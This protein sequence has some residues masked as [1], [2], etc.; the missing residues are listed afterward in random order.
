MPIQHMP[1]QR[2]TEY[3]IKKLHQLDIR[4]A[5]LRGNSGPALPQPL[6]L[7]LGALLM[8]LLGRYLL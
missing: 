2:V 1:V 3:S 8:M 5:H 4:S 7:I 6:F